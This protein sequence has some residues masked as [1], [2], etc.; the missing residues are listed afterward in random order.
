MTVNLSSQSN[1]TLTNWRQAGAWN[2]SKTMKHVLLQLIINISTVCPQWQFNSVI[3]CFY[4]LSKNKLAVSCSNCQLLLEVGR[5]ELTLWWNNFLL[6]AR[7]IKTNFTSWKN[8]YTK[9]ATFT[10]CGYLS[11]SVTS[12]SRYWCDC[13]FDIN[14]ML[15]PANAGKI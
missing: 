2:F 8:I 11:G 7:K 9:T 3:H 5:N 15:S 14:R 12:I 1:Q 4:K 10:M 13:E 6:T